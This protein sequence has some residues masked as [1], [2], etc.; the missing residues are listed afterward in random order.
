MSDLLK[1]LQDAQ[2]TSKKDLKKNINTNNAFGTLTDDEISYVLALRA[3][4]ARISSNQTQSEFSKKAKL[5]SATTYSNFEQNG[6]IS[7]INFIKVM[8]SFGRLDELENLLNETVK[9]K[10][11][12]FDT[13]EKQRVKKVK[14]L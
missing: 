1:K 5:S 6:R 4:K 11:N 12:K 2:K 14:K 8:R 3:K 10:I 13:K 7:L 9:E